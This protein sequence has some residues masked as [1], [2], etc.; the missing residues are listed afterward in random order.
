MN[1]KKLILSMIIIFI[2]IAYLFTSSYAKYKKDVEGDSKMDIAK[3]NIKVNDEF[4]TNKSKLTNNITPTF[5]GNEYINSSLIA[6]GIE[7]YYDINI[8]ATNVDTN[9]D[10]KIV[11]IVSDNSSVKDLI[12][13]GYTINPDENES[14][15]NY[16]NDTGITG[17]II[18]KT[19]STKFRIYIKWNDDND[20]QSM[21]NKEDTNVGTNDASTCI[22]NVQFKFIQK[23]DN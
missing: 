13:T 23:N 4:I 19:S 9:F 18:K 14:I 21:D 20:T 3:W 15:T 12:T 11:S 7:G 22:M 8:D 16:N 2:C 1:K 10:Y 5:I 17:T 6:P